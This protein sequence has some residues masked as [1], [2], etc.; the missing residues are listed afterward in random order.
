ML[1]R[2]TLLTTMQKKVPQW[3]HWGGGG[4]GGGSTR[5]ERNS[6]KR[7][8]FLDFNVQSTEQGHLRMTK[9]NTNVY[10]EEE[11]STAQEL[12]DSRGG[13]PGLPSLISL[14]FLLT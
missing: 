9:K 14:R 13:R 1:Q 3:K 6:K 10:E 5:K 7:S 2:T 12:C 8:S 11:E 4:G